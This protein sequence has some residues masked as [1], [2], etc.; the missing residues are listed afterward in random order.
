MFNVST[1]FFGSPSYLGRAAAVF[2]FVTLLAF[3]IGPFYWPASNAA[4][5]GFLRFFTLISVTLYLGYKAN[6][7]KW[8]GVGFSIIALLVYIALNSIFLEEGVQSVRRIIFIGFFVFMVANFWREPRLPIWLLTSLALIGAVFA[9]FSLINL[10]RLGELSSTYRAGAVFSSGVD[11]VAD[12]GNT[13]VAAMHY[14]VCFSAALW[15]LLRTESRYAVVVWI[16]CS[17]IIGAYTVMTFARTGWVA[18]LVVFIVLAIFTLRSKNWRRV[19]PVLISVSLLF[20]WF[21]LTYLDYELVRGVTHRDE[22]WLTVLER[23]QSHPFFGHGAGQPL[24]PISIKNGAAFVRTA[25]STYMEVLY[26]FG[27]VGLLMMLAL[28]L[29]TITVLSISAIKHRAV[30]SDV[31]ALA[32]FVAACIVMLVELNGF[33]DSPNLLW[34]WFWFPIGIALSHGGEQC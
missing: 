5:A 12:F 21:S 9:G 1:G 27:I 24:E 16:L 15:L 28:V 8:S 33:V 11:G 2:S 13:I 19:I 4:W 22:I 14:A 7:P 6:I 32:V 29:S 10:Y 20:I 18:S 23:A 17:L 31:W 3:F 26:Q 30:L 25:H 34:I